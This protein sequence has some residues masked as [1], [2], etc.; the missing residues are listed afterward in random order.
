MLVP[1]TAMGW[2]WLE[3]EELRDGYVFD[4]S[5]FK[6]QPEVE[7]YVKASILVAFS[8]SQ[9]K[10]RLTEFLVYPTLCDIL[11]FVKETVV[12]RFEPL[13]T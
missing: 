4:E 8:N 12:P 3:N 11:K 1:T 5:Y 6:G 13:F 2:T 10:G 7:M 9:S